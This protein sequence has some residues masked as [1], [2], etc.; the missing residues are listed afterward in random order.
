M[1]GGLGTPSDRVDQELNFRARIR[2]DRPDLHL[3]RFELTSPKARRYNC[4]AFAAGDESQW[5][6]PPRPGL[7]AYWPDGVSTSKA[8]ESLVAC[9][10]TLGYQEPATDADAA[11]AE[12][13][14][15]YMDD[16]GHWTHAARQQADGTSVSKMGGWE[17]IEHAEAAD[18]CG[19]AYGQVHMILER[20]RA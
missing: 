16:D 7:S 4:I 11:D 12:R 15:I 9:F 8:V 17:D 3:D 6:Q 20:P 5:W 2:G 13:V 1:L 14:A 10:R 19:P 18:V